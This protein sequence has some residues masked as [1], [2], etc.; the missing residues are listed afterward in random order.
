MQ[1][2]KILLSSLESTGVYCGVADNRSGTPV[3]VRFNPFAIRVKAGIICGVII[4]PFSPRANGDFAAMQ[5]RIFFQRLFGSNRLACIAILNSAVKA[6][7]RFKNA[8][9]ISGLSRY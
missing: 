1:A 8:V 5:L 4:V 7:Q 9:L 2:D 6:H 3:A